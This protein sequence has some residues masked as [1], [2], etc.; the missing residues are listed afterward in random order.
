[1]KDRKYRR[2]T[3]A[4]Q[5]DTIADQDGYIRYTQELLKV[6]VRQQ[7]YEFVGT[8]KIVLLITSG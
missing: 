4:F 8:Q 6:E 7:K 2:N 1:M 3:R 5:K